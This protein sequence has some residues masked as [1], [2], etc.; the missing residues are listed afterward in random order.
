M[1][2]TSYFT[3]V[4]SNAKISKTHCFRSSAFDSTHVKY[5]VWPTM[6]NHFFFVNAYQFYP[7]RNGPRFSLSEVLSFWWKHPAA[8]TSL[9]VQ[10]TGHLSLWKESTVNKDCWAAHTLTWNLFGRLWNL[11]TATSQEDVNYA[12]PLFWICRVNDNLAQ[13]QPTAIMHWVHDNH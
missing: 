11:Q 6:S 1:G 5:D 7:S 2:Q 12:P 4:E 10:N 13:R 3:C 9:Y 8:P